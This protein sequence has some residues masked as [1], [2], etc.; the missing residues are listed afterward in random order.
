MYDYC[1]MPGDLGN[2][3]ATAAAYV[4]TCADAG[5]PVEGQL[6]TAL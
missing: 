1:A 6:L 2:I 5:A 4:K 3:C